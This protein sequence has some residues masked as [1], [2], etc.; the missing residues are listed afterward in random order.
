MNT[1]NTS[2][3]YSPF[4]LHLGCSPRMLPPLIHNAKTPT[5]PEHQLVAKM[6]CN[7]QVNVMEAQ[8]NLLA[9][10]AAQAT[11]ANKHHGPPMMLHT[12]DHVMLATK[13]CWWEYI[14]KGDKRVAK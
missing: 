10:K 12:G 1:I 2:T 9:S 8:D 4:Q 7:L 11:T 6:M 14:Q 5:E 13:H 3:G